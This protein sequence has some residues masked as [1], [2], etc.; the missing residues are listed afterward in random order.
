MTD[1]LQTLAEKLQTRFGDALQECKLDRREITIEVPPMRAIEI[2]TA[3]R[4]E[5]EFAFEQV[6]DVCGV[7]YAAYG[8][9]EWATEESTTAGFSRGVVERATG[10]GPGAI[11]YAA[12][13]TFAGKGRFA[14]VYQLLSVSCNHRLRVRVFAPDDDLPVVPSVVGLW[15]SANWFEREAFDLFGIVF[16]GHPD[17]R[18]ILTDYGFVGHPFRKDFPLI[19]N[20]EMRYDPERGRVVY[21]PVSIEPRVLV[22]RVIRKDNRYLAS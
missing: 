4:D 9:V 17:L 6:M 1:A 8:D 21:E 14:A 10:R 20:V 7:D 5:P 12:G 15:S 16:E 13:K 22:P 18:R 2:F 3:L 19:G 11:Q